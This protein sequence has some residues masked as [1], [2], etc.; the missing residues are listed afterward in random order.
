MKSNFVYACELVHTDTQTDRLKFTNGINTERNPG[1]LLSGPDSFNCFAFLYGKWTFLT[2]F[3]DMQLP[4]RE[5]IGLVACT[6]FLNGG[7]L[8][9]RV[10]PSMLFYGGVDT[11]FF[12]FVNKG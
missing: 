12:A 5:S 4:N 8:E 11:T 10:L 6:G 1:L 2:K 9:K 3:M 7:K